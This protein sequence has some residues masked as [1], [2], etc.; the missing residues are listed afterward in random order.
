MRPLLLLL[1]FASFVTPQH[2][3]P[4]AMAAESSYRRVE[5]ESR[6]I[7]SGKKSP[8][9]QE[10]APPRPS[11][12]P[13]TPSKGASS[14]GWGLLARGS[15][16]RRRSPCRQRQRLFAPAPATFCHAVRSAAPIQPQPCYVLAD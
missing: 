3:Q 7:T 16:G 9:P 11:D 15:G 1:P 8:T 4:A 14:Q 5:E 10:R 6:E 12:M 13:G 2:Q